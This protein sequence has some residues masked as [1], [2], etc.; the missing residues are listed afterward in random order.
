MSLTFCHGGQSS[1]KK[2]VCAS[3]G[4]GPGTP[5]CFNRG[6]TVGIYIN[7]E[8]VLL[9]PADNEINRR[10]L[11][12]ENGIIV[13]QF[14]FKNLKGMLIFENALREP[15]IVSDPRSIRVHLELTIFN[16]RF[17]VNNSE[18]N[19]DTGQFNQMIKFTDIENT[20]D[21]RTG[22][23]RPEIFEILLWQKGRK[24]NS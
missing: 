2:P 13:A 14:E 6:L 16:L 4:P 8:A 15:T 22:K 12:L 20:T 7:F 23:P 24:G 17:N 1:R 5:Q 9:G 11:G 21:L 10:Q 3:T 19:W 18:L